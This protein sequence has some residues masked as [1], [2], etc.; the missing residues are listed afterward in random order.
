MMRDIAIGILLSF[1]SYS[2]FGDNYKQE[3]VS[4]DNSCR[5]LYEGASD[6]GEGSF[7]DIS[8]GKRKLIVKEYVRIGPQINWMGNSIA[9]LFEGVQNSVSQQISIIS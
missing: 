1:C 9:E 2:V 4:P 5:I 6:H 3:F 8:S 7:Y